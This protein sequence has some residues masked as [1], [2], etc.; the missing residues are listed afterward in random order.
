MYAEKFA[1]ADREVRDIVLGVLYEAAELVGDGAMNPR[2]CGDM[3]KR[4]SSGF[5]AVR[6]MR[7]AERALQVAIE[8]M[9]IGYY[10]ED[11]TRTVKARSA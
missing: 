5:R 2:E 1:G 9:P 7:E 10:A 3:V 6:L 8:G 4:V 11:R